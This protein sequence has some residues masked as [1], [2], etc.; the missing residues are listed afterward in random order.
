MPPIDWCKICSAKS[1][2]AGGHLLLLAKTKFP[3]FVKP[4]PWEPFELVKVNMTL[5]DTKLFDFLPTGIFRFKVIAKTKRNETIFEIN[6][7]CEL[8]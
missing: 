6:V 1:Q 4:C 7:V 3:E 8:Y 5:V 2:S